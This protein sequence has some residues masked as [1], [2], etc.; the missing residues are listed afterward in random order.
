MEKGDQQDITHRTCRVPLRILNTS[1]WLEL[2]WRRMEKRILKGEQTLARFSV[3]RALV[4][5]GNGVICQRDDDGDLELKVRLHPKNVAPA[6]L[7]SVFFVG[8][9]YSWKVRPKE[10][11]CDEAPYLREKLC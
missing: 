4:V 6:T 5:R 7:L 8:L 10:Q 3:D 2:R 11:F 1:Q 9:R